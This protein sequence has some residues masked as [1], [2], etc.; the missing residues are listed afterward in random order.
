MQFTTTVHRCT[1]DL[2]T[3]P[4]TW[5]IDWNEPLVPTWIEQQQDEWDLDVDVQIT[6][7]AGGVVVRCGDRSAVEEL[8][9]LALLH[10][11]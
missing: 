9:V 1:G 4:D 3:D 2:G 10:V 5:G 8:D 11:E 7:L 6:G